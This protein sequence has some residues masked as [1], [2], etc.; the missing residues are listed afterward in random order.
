[1]KFVPLLI[2]A[3]LLI[4]GGSHAYAGCLITNGQTLCTGDPYTFPN[5]G[6][7]PYTGGAVAL[8]PTTALNVENVNGL[9]TP[10]PGIA[11]AA[12]TSVVTGFDL[13]TGLGNSAK[14][15]SV[16]M[17]RVSGNLHQ[18][19]GASFVDARSVGADGG[20]TAGIGKGG[21][22]GAGGDV[23]VGVRFNSELRTIAKLPQYRSVITAI[24]EGGNGG[25]ARSFSA[26]GGDGGQPGNVKVDN[27]ADLTLLQAKAGVAG[28]WAQSLGGAGGD[29]ASGFSKGGSSSDGGS[30]TISSLGKITVEGDNIGIFAQSLGGFA[31]SGGGNTG[32]ASWENGKNTYG[33]NDTSAGRGGAVAIVNSGVV[34]SGSISIFAQSIG[35]GGGAGL[36]L[37]GLGSRGGPGGNGGSVNV[38]NNGDLTV[39]GTKSASGIIAQSV[40]GG[41]GDGGEAFSVGLVATAIGGD[42]GKGGDGAS[43][44]VNG[45]I[46]SLG[47]C[48]ARLDPNLK[49]T[50]IST[51]SKNSAGIIAQSVGGGGGLGGGGVAAGVFGSFSMGGKGGAAGRGG[52]VFAGAKGLIT[53][54]QEFSAGIDASSTGGGGGEGGY[55]I[56]ASAGPVT[57]NT[58]LGGSGGSGNTGGNVTIDNSA[59]ITTSGSFS[60]ALSG[61]SLGGG[62]GGAGF[63][64]AAGISLA[65]LNVAIGGA[66]GA[67]ASAG[68]VSIQNFGNLTT[69]GV[70][71]A[72]I[73]AQSVGGGGG[74]GG[75]AVAAGVSA[76]ADLKFAIGGDGAGGGAGGNV[77]VTSGSAPTSSAIKTSGDLSRGIFAQSVGGSGGSGG[78]S[79]GAGASL[80]GTVSIAM[81][82]KGAAG[83]TGGAVNVTNYSTIETLGVRSEGLYAQSVGG[84]GGDGGFAVAAGGA[85]FATLSLSMGGNAGGGG[86]A[87]NVSVSQFGSISTKGQDSAAIYAQSVG[88]GGGHGGFSV[89][90]AGAGVASLA[91]SFG[92]AGSDGGKGANVSVTHSGASLSTMAANSDGLFAQSVGGGGGQGGF[93]ASGALSVAPGAAVA[94]SFG[95]TGGGGGDS[96]NVTVTSR[97]AGSITT[98]GDGSRGIAAQS[99]GG[100]GGSGGFSAAVGAS[101][102]GTVGLTI[103]G[104]GTAGGNSSAVTV[105]NDARISTLGAQSVGLLAQSV[106]G[107]GGDAGFAASGAGSKFGAVSISLG[108]TGGDGGNGGV[109]D[110]SN[111]GAIT[112]AGSNAS[113]IL[114]QSA[115]KGGG[116]GGMA[117]SGAVGMGNVIYSNGGSGGGGGTGAN[118]SVKNTANLAASGDESSGIVVESIGGG[119]GKGGMVVAAGLSA[120]KITGNAIFA[121]GGLGGAGASG[122]AATVINNGAIDVSG[123]NAEGIIA[124]SIGGGGGDGGFSV[125]AKV[126]GGGEFSGSYISSLGGDGGVGNVGGRVEVVN[127]G[128]VTARGA[129]SVGILAQSIG[130]GGGNG[131][132]AITGE[133]ENSG[134]KSIK[135]TSVIGGKGG[136]TNNIGGA[137]AIT[138]NGLITTSGNESEGIVAESIGGGGG[139]GGFVVGGKLTVSN[140]KDATN[141]LAAL[142][143]VGG[144]GN[145]GG[146]VCVVGGYSNP[147]TGC[148]A[149][150]DVSAARSQIVTSGNGSDGVVAQ[151]VGGGGGKGGFSITGNLSLS[152]KTQ[153]STVGGAGGA[154]GNGA[155]SSV[156]YAG[157]IL[158]SGRNAPA[159]LAQSIGGGGGKGG[160]SVEGSMTSEGVTDVDKYGT[161]A[162]QFVGLGDPKSGGG[163]GGGAGKGGDVTVN[164]NNMAA[165]RGVILT[166]QDF[167][168]GILAQS[169][170]GGGGFGA[171]SVSGDFTAKKGG[172]SASSVGGAGG[173]GNSAGSVTV[174]AGGA[175]Y[176]GA[177][178]ENVGT[179]KVVIASGA[180][181]GSHAI[182]AQSIGGAGGFGGFAVS[183][184]F[185]VADGKGSS[186]AVGGAGGAGS[187]GGKV[188]VATL[189]GARL[190]TYGASAN[191]ILAQSIG[192]GGGDGAFAIGAGYSS[193]ADDEIAQAKNYVGGSKGTTGGSGGA[194]GLGSEVVVDNLGTIV[195]H[196]N[197]ANGIEAQSIGGGGGDGAFAISAIMNTLGNVS[198]NVGGG[199]GLTGGNAG[200]VTVTNGGSIETKG[201]NSI[202]VLAESIGG[203][204]GNGAFAIGAAVSTN[205][206]AKNNVGGGDGGTGGTPDSV[207]VSNNG[208]IRTN[209]A[210]SMGILAQAIAG[211]GGNGSFAISASKAAEVKR[212]YFAT[213]QIGATGGAGGV[214]G[215]V[216]V[217][218]IVTVANNGQ[219]TTSG[220]MSTAI[221]AQSIGGGGGNGGFAINGAI[222]D[223]AQK[224]ADE[225]TAVGGGGGAGGDGGVVRVTNAGSIILNGADST[226]ILAQ[227]VG[228]GGGNGGFF[229]SLDM[230][231]KRT[232]MT[233]GQTAGGNG[234]WGA[235]VSVKSTGSITS[236]AENSVAVLAQSIGGGGG[237]FGWSL[238]AQNKRSKGMKFAVGSDG[239][240]LPGV[241]LGPVSVEISGGNITTTGA[242][243]HGLLAQNIAGGGGNLSFSATSPLVIETEVTS[244]KEVVFEQRLGASSDATGTTAGADAG[245][246]TVSN[247]NNIKTSGA[248][249]IGFLSQAIGG[250]GGVIGATGDFTITGNA[251]WDS[252]L[253]GSA[254]SLGGK[255]GDVVATN[256]ALSVLTSGSSAIG[257]LAQSIGGG[258]GAIINGSQNFLMENA[259][260]FV[261]RDV[262]AQLGSEG[263][264]GSRNNSGSIRLTTGGSTM[265]TGEAASAVVGQAI[266]GGGGVFGMVVNNTTSLGPTMRRLDIDLILGGK[267][268]GGSTDPT[269]ASDWKIEKG[270]I[271]TTG[272]FSN[273][274]VAQ[275]IGGGGGLAA[276]VAK[277]S[278]TAGSTILLGG[279][280]NSAGAAVE[281]MNGGAVTL[282]NNSSIKTT[283]VGAHGMVAQSIGGGG[284][285]AQI[286]GQDPD[287]GPTVSLGYSGATVDGLNKVIYSNGSDVNIVSNNS[288]TTTYSNTVGIVAQSIGGGGGL[289]QVVK[290]DGSISQFGPLATYKGA[291]N[292]G[293]VTVTQGQNAPINVTGAG[294]IGILAQSVAG[295][296][297]YWFGDAA[298][299]PRYAGSNGG[300]GTSGNVTINVNSNVTATGLGAK[301]IFAQS[302]SKGLTDQNPN[303]QTGTGKVKINIAS[304]V[305][306]TGDGPDASLAAIQQPSVQDALH[307]GLGLAVENSEE[308]SFTNYGTLN[309][310]NGA[311]GIAIYSTAGN[312]SIVNYGR[313]VGSYVSFGGPD[314]FIN[315]AFHSVE[316][317]IAHAGVFDAGAVVDLGAGGQFTNEGAFIIGGF[318]DGLNTNLTGNYTQT[319]N[320]ACGSYGAP[321]TSCGY[322]AADVNVG[323]GPSGHLNISGTADVSGAIV[324]NPISGGSAKPGSGT[325]TV[326]RAAGGLTTNNL[327]LQAPTSAVASY[328]L[329][330]NANEIGVNYTVNFAPVG[331][332]FNQRAPAFA[333]NAIQASG[334]FPAF[335][336]VANAL[337]VQ[338]N[339]LALGAAYNSLSGEGVTASQQTTFMANDFLHSSANRQMNFWLYDQ[340]DNGGNSLTLYDDRADIAPDRKWR[341]TAPYDTRAPRFAERTWKTW[342]I[343]SGGALAYPG[344][345]STGSANMSSGG[346]GFAGGVDRQ[347]TPNFLVGAAGGYGTYG[348]GVQQRQTYGNVYGGHVAGYAALK[349]GPFYATGVLS[350][351]FFDNYAHRTV[352]IAGSPTTTLF[353][354]NAYTPGVYDNLNGKFGSRSLSGM[355]EA[356]Y[357]AKVGALDVTPFAALQFSSLRSDGFNE[358]NGFSK[359]VVALNYQGRTISS[360][361][362]YVGMQ[363][364]HN[365]ELGNG[366]PLWG[367][368]RSAWRHEF[369]QLRT[370]TTAF[371]AA[372]GMNFTTLGAPGVRDMAWVSSGVKLGLTPNLALFAGFDGNFAPSAYAVSG[373]GGIQMRW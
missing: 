105:V 158:T 314:I 143:G 285:V 351:D 230:T 266:S 35:G 366:M 328:G 113:A 319:G 277:G 129:N 304:G 247:A 318:Y 48:A 82:G 278:L 38:T 97:G 324:V 206:T 169:L 11:G 238:D 26:D 329:T 44:C 79:V 356:G 59:S 261:S 252:L 172:A 286:F 291:G 241:G 36:S 243:S 128:A 253:G 91:L 28:I 358:Y 63:S 205:G 2:G 365:F 34:N 15:V 64:V 40:G 19:T 354:E 225:S 364:N 301:A 232:T 164:L 303:S 37:L 151:S 184:G 25:D 8:S 145:D 119:G 106:G 17:S 98:I 297:G 308:F 62:G 160:F 140:S 85:K 67:G 305:V 1:M 280:E 250:G 317:P 361:P 112:T 335:A 321:T 274:V 373:S 87:S 334:A 348:F 340:E 53:T 77:T 255:G 349:G 54:K 124:Q 355:G 133:I 23:N 52:D 262:R 130:D 161:E 88:G 242:V 209:G 47:D 249:S 229:G 4:S 131:G 12:A 10:P 226:G 72:G 218:T 181:V 148:V 251:K 166:S 327:Q 83:A 65:G 110:V 51:V 162:L 171:F 9:I 309:V 191:G 159:I 74:S 370:V 198:N 115:G 176:T 345:A 99:L 212:T 344:Q 68:T 337:F 94:L 100:G 32:D 179:E 71:S 269:N 195:V 56:A 295:G 267:G 22:G 233:V 259:E 30:V 103:G 135:R 18:T 75:W 93:S 168:H 363:F 296:G 302:A 216:P 282:T 331:L 367:W 325:T 346:Y 264:S 271:Q 270:D 336:P 260:S 120:G 190:E 108:R 244:G 306:V 173:A 182:E 139:R 312:D 276:F 117:L 80:G 343:G 228:G 201:D 372:P 257:V 187:D 284:G 163:G 357:R 78:F 69:S 287:N 132:A 213:Q 46:N 258:G 147:Q 89:S 157:D 313:I 189:A 332:T 121:S 273:G 272:I 13:W 333:V 224:K 237:N 360:L 84:G 24:S 300:E 70:E 235:A 45:T 138:N 203:G 215:S 236:T 217:T 240:G 279:Q 7:F 111:G 178:I 353:D 214:G 369:D 239:V 193:K 126:A 142:G 368:V 290:G 136:A 299:K 57:I 125:A 265:T 183:G 134:D 347:I 326:L 288:I 268:A 92:G 31:G 204:G 194:G 141:S 127:T 202:G 146:S 254:S 248:A 109:V 246:V 39:T 60:S 341:A 144:V 192:G 307:T 177:K 137:V 275:S 362:S 175:I 338:P 371:M 5:V 196:G 149:R 95:G 342:M 170:G 43:V 220:P 96:S 6:N 107:G 58:S 102:F 76:L 55:A 294:S 200:A 66:G 359:S 207:T 231:N 234:G 320:G 283:G 330:T 16:E 33:I 73:F 123:A 298:G 185:A 289:V 114:A 221:E 227:S 350:G 86:D 116:A 197:N 339:V 41:G 174:T 118:V 281:A 188:N 81:G 156:W 322:L 316:N 3:L 222:A 245:S 315:K 90:G 154:G 20:V 352:S 292:G 311:K 256:T 155:A 42:G 104:E 211:G 165:S 180:G 49:A 167:S 208:Q 152:T 21:K 50:T 310:V 293:N 263:L 29:A 223:K 219:I 122:G 27:Q 210:N 14:P 199:S 61:R 150:T 153:A 323:G 101:Q 186:N